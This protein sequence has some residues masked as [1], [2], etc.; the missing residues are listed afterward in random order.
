MQQQ[1]QMAVKID[2]DSG[3]Q[4]QWYMAMKPQQTAAI[5]TQMG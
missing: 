1:Q 5:A 3:R 2:K 4:Q